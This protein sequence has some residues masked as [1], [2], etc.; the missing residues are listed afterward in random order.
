MIARQLGDAREPDALA[1]G[2]AVRDDERHL[3][4][5]IEQHAQAAHAYVVV[6]EDDRFAS[7]EESFSRTA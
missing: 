3:H 7:Q 1:G 5:R 6:R 4:A 2:V